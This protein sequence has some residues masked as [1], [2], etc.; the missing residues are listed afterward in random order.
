MKI[1][2]WNIGYLLGY[3]NILGGYVPPLIDSVIGDPT[4]ERRHLDRIVSVIERERPDVVS[5]IEVD[6]GSY[7]TITQGQFHAILS[8]LE[9]RELRYEGTIANKYSEDGLFASLPFYAHLGNGVLARSDRQ[10]RTHYLDAGRKSLVIEVGL[11][12]DTVMFVV[13]LPLGAR[14]RRRQLTEL[15]G[16]IAV[17]AEGREVIVTGDF[18]TFAETRSLE[19]F[20]TQTGLKRCDTGATIPSRPFDEYLLE[21]RTID[22]FLCSPE[23]AVDR[24]EAIDEQV[25]DHRPVVLEAGV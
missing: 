7:R 24:C 20:E 21:S 19:E 13:H 11:D 1:L 10:I 6:R 5:L 18:N 12:S 25:S 23:I 4:L 16:V 15:A 3:Q 14:S 8:K 17:R 2:S 9:D 22:L